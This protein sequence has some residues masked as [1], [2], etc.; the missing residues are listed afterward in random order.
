V[1][2]QHYYR[3]RGAHPW[4]VCGNVDGLDENLQASRQDAAKRHSNVE[5][6][7]CEAF[8]ETLLRSSSKY[9]VLGLPASLGGEI[10]KPM[11]EKSPS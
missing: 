4:A 1:E 5:R 2:G 7:G 9:L 8:C 10:A 6:Y 3:T 11:N